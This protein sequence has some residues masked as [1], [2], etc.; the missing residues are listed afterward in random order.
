MVFVE[1]TH[2]RPYFIGGKTETEISKMENMLCIA[3][4]RTIVK[5]VKDFIDRTRTIHI[6]GY[7]FPTPFMFYMCYIFEYIVMWHMF[8]ELPDS[9]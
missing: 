1:V 7:F 6:N 2:R 4:H 9:I 5:I 8:E 3:H